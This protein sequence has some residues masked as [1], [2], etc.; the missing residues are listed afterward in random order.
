MI[1][2]QMAKELGL[3]AEFVV[4]LANGASHEY[5][6]YEIPKRTG[7]SRIIYHP[8][9]RLKALQ[10]WLLRRVI[11]L[12]P[13]HSAAVAYQANRSI[14]DNA[15]AHSS[16]RYLLRMDL[17]DFF[18]SLTQDDVL[19]YMQSRITLFQ[20]WTGADI[21]VFCLLVTRH[22]RLTIGAPSS[23]ALSNALCY[24]LDVQLHELSK[25]HSSTY[26]R[27]A[28]D[29][30]FSTDLPDVLDRI[31]PAVVEV[32]R[33]LALPAGLELNAKKT[34]HSSKRGTRRVTGITL[35]SDGKPYIG[36]GFKRRIR[37]LIH[38]LDELDAN[39]RKSLSGMIAYA[40][41]FDPEFI[42]SLILKYGLP[43]VQAAMKG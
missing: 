32:I 26:T 1:I 4:S 41:G 29:L 21:E 12:L 11:N 40:R 7:G 14:F 13:V 9:R 34:R 18:P 17:R 42:N 43:K 19:R 10:R 16:S 33:S 3:P 5:K 24:D 8:S 30:F 20:G 38:K 28:D 27:Y 22:S 37:A 2:E 15:S 23:P 35:G 39:S 31:E 6:K 36:R 25:R